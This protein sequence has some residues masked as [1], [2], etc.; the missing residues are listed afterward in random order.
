MVLYGFLNNCLVSSS[1]LTFIFSGICASNALTILRFSEVAPYKLTCF[2]PIGTLWINISSVLLSH[3]QFLHPYSIF[4]NIGPG[5]QLSATFIIKKIFA[6]CMLFQFSSVVQ[7]C[8]TLCKPMD[9]SKPG[10]P[11]HHQLLEFTQTHVHWISDAIQPSHP[12]STPSLP[13]FNLSQHQG[14][15][16]CIG[17]SHQVV[18]VSEFQLQHQSF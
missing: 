6:P 11:V 7:L 2:L 9:C 14:L 4:I 18:K 5:F 13:T 17:S 8:P 16:Q 10:L 1:H 3:L 15:F 12:L